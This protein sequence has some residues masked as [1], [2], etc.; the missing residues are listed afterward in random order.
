MSKQRAFR[1]SL[2]TLF[3]AVTGIGLFLGYAHWRRVTILREEA[4]LEAHGIKLLWADSGREAIWPVIPREARFEYREVS[5]N[6]VEIASVSY[7]L[8]D[9]MV[10]S[11]S[12]WQRLSRFGVAE[13]EIVKNRKRTN[14]WVSTQS[15]LSADEQSHALE[16]AAGPDSNG[17][18]SPPAQ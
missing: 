12:L 9:A 10:N 15:T 13:V 16:P 7:S 5:P 8:D 4:D 18:S 6:A 3:V 2:S 1:F 11:D 14:T 17:E